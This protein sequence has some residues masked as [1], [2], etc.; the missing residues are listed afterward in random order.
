MDA[1][2]HADAWVRR[3]EGGVAVDLADRVLLGQQIAAQGDHHRLAVSKG[4]QAVARLLPIGH[5]LADA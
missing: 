2:L 3:A 1:V 5:G 4:N